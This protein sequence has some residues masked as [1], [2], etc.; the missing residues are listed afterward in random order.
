MIIVRVELHS[1]ITGQV[2]ELARAHISNIG[3]TNESRDYE[4][5]TLRGRSK[6][7]LDRH[8]PQRT[9]KVL[10]YPSLREHVWNL[11]AKALTGMGYGRSS[12]P[13][14]SVTERA[15][16]PQKALPLAMVERSHG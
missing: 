2:T 16:A 13:P 14:E 12:A 6:A 11:V 9:G 15:P 3:G 5:V 1:A 10:A 7:T 4:C 8:V